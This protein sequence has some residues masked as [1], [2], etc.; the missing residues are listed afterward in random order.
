MLIL[1]GV[2]SVMTVATHTDC[3]EANVI[4]G[5]ICPSPSERNDGPSRGLISKP[6]DLAWVDSTP[7]QVSSGPLEV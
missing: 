2:A 5:E 7:D 3:S 4:G 6:G 1:A